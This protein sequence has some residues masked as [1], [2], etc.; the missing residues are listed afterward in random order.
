MSNRKYYAAKFGRSKSASH[1]IGRKIK[2]NRLLEAG[3]NFRI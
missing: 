3:K 2:P 1:E